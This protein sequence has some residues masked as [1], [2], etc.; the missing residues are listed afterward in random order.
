MREALLSSAR[1]PGAALRAGVAWGRGDWDD[2][3][4][5]ITRFGLTAGVLSRLYSEAVLWAEGHAQP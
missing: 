3:E 1:P 4:R 2:V 5:W